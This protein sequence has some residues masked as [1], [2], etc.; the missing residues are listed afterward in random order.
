MSRASISSAKDAFDPKGTP[1]EK[2]TRT[3][4]YLC[5]NRFCIQFLFTSGILFGLLVLCLAF[6]TAYYGLMYRAPS[7]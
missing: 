4:K 3:E 5:M 2:I 1:D 7:S 6:L